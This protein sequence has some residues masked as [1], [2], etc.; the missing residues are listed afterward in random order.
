MM[1]DDRK[2]R[3]RMVACQ[4]QARG[5]RDVR[6][7]EAMC[8]VPRE[9]FVPHHLAGLAYDDGPLPIGEGQT[10]SQPYIVAVMVEAAQV[11]SDDRVLE[12]G[13]GSGYAAAVL[14]HLAGHVF[15]I[16]RH[17]PLAATAAERLTRLGYEN[18][19]V[20]AGDGSS[21]LL[22]KAP[23]D[24]ILVAARAPRVPEAFKHQLA[25]GGRLVIPVGGEDVQTL[26]RLTRTSENEWT[27]AD[28]GL[29]RFVPLVGSQAV[30]L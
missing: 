15:T 14:A 28:L 1:G 26:L 17:R 11:R 29:V 13:A 30:E 6:V 2:R 8:A 23:F 20:I 27:S 16:E 7:I 19:T 22:S 24:A 5:I 25:I 12:V 18:V 3:D 4:I 21:G 10:I 9:A